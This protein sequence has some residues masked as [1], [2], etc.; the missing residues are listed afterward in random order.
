V[1]LAGD[2]ERAGPVAGASAQLALDSRHGL[3][4]LAGQIEQATACVR[5]PHA[6]AAAFEEANAQAFLEHFE[7][8]ADGRLA[9]GE[10]AA[11]TR[12]PAGL[13]DGPNEPKV[14]CL[15]GCGR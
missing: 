7:L 15:E 10:Q 11:R 12:Q 5:H 3:E 2:P 8:M 6:A 4:N 14:A 1:A 9:E 13:G